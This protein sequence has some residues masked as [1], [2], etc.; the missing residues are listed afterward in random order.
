[1]YQIEK[2]PWGLKLTFADFIQK[3]EMEK[4]VQE[5]EQT[6]KDQKGSFGV[7]VDMRTLKPLP[8]D[9]QE[10]MEEGQRMFKE[11]GMS[12][13]AVVLS[14]ALTTMQFKRIAHETGI[15]QWERYIDASA[16]SDWEGASVAWIQGGV[17]PEK[18]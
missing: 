1:M 15:S 18:K 17:D 16:T 3:N 11:K 6:L 9:A 8:K 14:S 2:K 7:L 10:K 4:W 12:R 13:S 5:A